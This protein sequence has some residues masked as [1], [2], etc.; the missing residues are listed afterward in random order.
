MVLTFVGGTLM[1]HF[2]DNRSVLV[3]LIGLGIIAIAVIGGDMV[4]ESLITKGY[5][6]REE[7]TLKIAVTGV[8]NISGQAEYMGMLSA[9]VILYGLA[10]L[11][12]TH[13]YITTLFIF[14]I[15]V[16][17]LVAVITYTKEDKQPH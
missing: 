3:F 6:V 15:G 17:M 7:N 5:P 14:A 12:K 8:E 16:L 4:R 2:V 1:Y 13:N 11:L 9:I 10:I